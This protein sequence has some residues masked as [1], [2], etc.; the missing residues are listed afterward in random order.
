MNKL[1]PFLFL[2]LCTNCK[3]TFEDQSNDPLYLF[4]TFWQEVDRNYAFFSYSTLNWDSVYSLYQPQIQSN[5]TEEELLKIFDK[6][7]SVLHDAHTNIYTPIGIGGNTDYFSQFPTNE[8]DDISTYIPHLTSNNPAFSYGNIYNHNLGYIKIKTFDSDQAYYT[9]FDTLLAQFATKKGIILDLRSNRGGLISN[10]SVLLSHLSD[11]TFAA[12]KYRYRNG[13]GHN[14]FSEWT[15]FTVSSNR[16]TS[17]PPLTILTNRQSFSACEWFIAA[18]SELPFVTSIGDTTGGGSAIPVTRELANG[19]V[20]RI[21]NTQTL[22]PLGSDYQ[23]TGL[24][25]DIPVWISDEDAANN[26]DTILERAISEL[27]Q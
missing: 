6:M 9:H 27:E 12:F 21:S 14:N 26:I 4:D 23:F 25:P 8:I 3:N 19:W 17:I 18:A 5:M 2:L 7:L 16:N 22:L 10:T 24:Y 20:L 11:S 15:A 13:M 1:L